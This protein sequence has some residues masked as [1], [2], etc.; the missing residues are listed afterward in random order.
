MLKTLKESSDR[1]IFHTLGL[2]SPNCQIDTDSDPDPSYHFDA[3]A[4]PDL[5]YHFD[6]DADLDLTFQFD[7]DSDP[8]HCPHWVSFSFCKV[9]VD[10]MCRFFSAGTIY[11]FI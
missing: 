5:V 4:D 1:L 2:S 11:C 10:F 9:P 8:Y 7:P 3:D 6:V